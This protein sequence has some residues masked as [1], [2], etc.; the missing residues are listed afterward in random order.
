MQC[1]INAIFYTIGIKESYIYH[2]LQIT[3]YKELYEK[4]GLH[5]VYEKSCIMV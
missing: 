3:V 1:S 4:S 5:E 2:L